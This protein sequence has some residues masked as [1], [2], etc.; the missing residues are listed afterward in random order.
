MGSTV[1]LLRLSGAGTSDL[2][3][4]QVNYRIEPKV[5]ANLKGQGG[6]AAARGITVP[7]IVEGPWHDLSYKPDLA[8]M[9]KDAL[10]DPTKALGAVKDLQEGATGGVGK[11][12]E[13][14]IKPGADS[15][16]AAK[17]DIGG[18]L[19]KLLGN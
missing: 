12:L 16:G 1:G 19:K 18:A 3:A 2:P 13:S 9:L 10:T 15:G 17:P 4:R 6:D 11:L 7:V 5:V 8:G 14:L